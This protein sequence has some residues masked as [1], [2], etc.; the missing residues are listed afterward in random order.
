[1]WFRRKKTGAFSRSRGSG[2]TVDAVMRSWPGTARA[3][4]AHR[5]GCVGCPIGSFHTVEEACKEHKIGID[6]FLAALSEAAAGASP[7]HS[8]EDSAI[9]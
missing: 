6:G 1:M 5:M 9:K 4:L 3:F 7:P 2:L 8:E